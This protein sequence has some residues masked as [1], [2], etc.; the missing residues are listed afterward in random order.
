MIINICKKTIKKNFYGII[1]EIINYSSIFS[2][3][4]YTST[5]A[6]ASNVITTMTPTSQMNFTNNYGTDGNGF[7]FS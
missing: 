7:R 3:Y 1:I 5:L 2:N 4:S 6:T